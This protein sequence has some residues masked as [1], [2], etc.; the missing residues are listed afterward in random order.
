MKSD[1]ILDEYLDDATRRLQDKVN[2]FN[3]DVVWGDI[4]GDNALRYALNLWKVSWN[5]FDYVP[6]ERSESTSKSF[7]R[8]LRDLT[9]LHQFLGPQTNPPTRDFSMKFSPEINRYSL[10]NPP[11]SYSSPI[12][13]YSDRKTDSL[14]DFNDLAA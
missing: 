13:L 1:P 9:F 7:C 5:L 3:S 12:L 4:R 14:H 2:S 6:D 8:L 10:K 11:F